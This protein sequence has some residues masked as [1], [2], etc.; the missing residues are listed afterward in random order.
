M[1]FDFEKSHWKVQAKRICLHF[2]VE[3][4][5]L[6]FWQKWKENY[7]VQLIPV[8]S[9]SSFHLNPLPSGQFSLF[10]QSYLLSLIYKWKKKEKKLNH[11]TT[12]YLKTLI[13]CE[14][15]RSSHNIKYWCWQ[16]V[17]PQR[18]SKDFSCAFHSWQ[19]AEIC[20][21]NG[22]TGRDLTCCTVSFH[23]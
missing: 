1:G 23:F 8:W 16:A 2:Y 13:F 15:I 14:S 3:K 22:M 9:S 18:R 4:W 10:N 5:L 6:W 20:H 19:V 12:N 11:K 17:L 21:L 7:Y